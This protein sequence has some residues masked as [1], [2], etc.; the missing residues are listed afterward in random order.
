METTILVT[1]AN[2]GLGFAICCRLIDDFPKRPGHRLRLIYSTRS[3]TKANETL[4]R[5]AT[6]L[7]RRDDVVCESVLVD[8]TQLRSVKALADRL[9]EAGQRL[10][11]V[12]WNAGIAGWKGTN[13]RKATWNICTHFVH[14]LTYPTFMITDVGLKA[15]EQVSPD[16]DALGQVF[17]ANVFG[18]YMLTHWLA[19]LFGPDSRIIWISSVSAIPSTFTLDDLQ[20][21]H[22]EVA[23]ESSKRLTD[24]LILTSRL[25]STRPWVSTFLPPPSTKMYLAHPGVVGTSI[26]DLPPLL[27]LLMLAVMYVVRLVGSP[28][29]PVRPYKGAL[30]AVH[31]ALAPASEL[32]ALEGDNGKGKWGTAT[33][34][35]GRDRV[36]RT[37][38]G[39]WGFGGV[40]GAVPPD[41][42]TSSIARWKTWRETDSGMR[43]RFEDLG[44][45]CWQEME[46]L[47]VKWATAIK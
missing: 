30:S 11:R 7:K 41:S 42:E 26:A 34:V 20:G 14:S 18:H 24:L 4:R 21:L 45:K 9:V 39:G 10:D 22:S 33:D 38:V 43:E 46:D 13:W 23:Y 29:F 27:S 16:E 36:A 25:P 5:L 6:H 28:W 3:S 19:P 35:W 47:R 8:L 15:A 40:V 12:I 1:G 17:L 44:R 31:L 2:S 37:E 32:E